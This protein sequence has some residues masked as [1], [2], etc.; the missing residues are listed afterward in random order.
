MFRNIATVGLL[1]LAMVTPLQQAKAQDPAL[2]GAIIGG[3]IGA[4]VGGAATGRAGGAIAG[5]VIGAV[6]GASIA[7]SMEP[8]RTG[9]YAYQGDC[10][11]RR[12][13]GSYVRTYRRYCE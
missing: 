13:D 11:R 6:L 4:G 12:G 10:W 1:T 8:R 5:G 3:V 7:S 9:Y 2:G